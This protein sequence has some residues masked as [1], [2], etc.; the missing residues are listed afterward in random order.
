MSKFLLIILICVCCQGC[1][2]IQSKF[3]NKQNNNL[4][5]QQENQNQEKKSE[6]IPINP[7]HS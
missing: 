2:F 4:Q 3:G 5:N 1:S 7:Q 6:P